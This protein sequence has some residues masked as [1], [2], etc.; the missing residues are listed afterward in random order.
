MK[1]PTWLRWL[2]IQLVA[3][4][5]DELADDEFSEKGRTGA[6]LGELLLFGGVVLILLGIG[7][8]GVALLLLAVLS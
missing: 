7:I 8:G 5:P 6:G 3:D 4:C 1:C 2:N